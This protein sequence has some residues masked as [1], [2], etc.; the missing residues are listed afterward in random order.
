MDALKKKQT[1]LSKF[2]HFFQFLFPFYSNRSQ[3]FLLV[4]FSRCRFIRNYSS[5]HPFHNNNNN[6]KKTTKSIFTSSH[7]CVGLHVLVV[8]LCVDLEF[9]TFSPPFPPLFLTFSLDFG[10]SFLFFFFVRR[11]WTSQF[12][13]LGSI[14][15]I[16]HRLIYEMKQ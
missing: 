8:G 11:L 13:P 15:L 2:F 10:F 14:S 12:A 4:I 16:G 6:Q 1:R 7:C 9:P 5:C 3:G